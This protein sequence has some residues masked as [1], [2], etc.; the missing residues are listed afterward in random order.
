MRN[1]KLMYILVPA[2]LAIWGFIGYQVARHLKSKTSANHGT[3]PTFHKIQETDTITF[4]LLENYRDPFLGRVQANSESSTSKNTKEKKNDPVDYFTLQ[5]INET[6][7]QVSYGGLIEGQG[8]GRMGLFRIK[9]KNCFLR[10]GQKIDEFEVIGLYAD[11][12]RIW[13]K[14]HEKTI[15]KRSN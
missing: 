13:N 10:Q 11:S 1:K 4:T 6:L 8:D 7:G 9:D 3:L 12:A 14:G 2:V 5:R 15:I